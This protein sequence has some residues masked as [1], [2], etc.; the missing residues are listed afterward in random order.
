M[1]FFVVACSAVLSGRCE[2]LYSDMQIPVVRQVKKFLFWDIKMCCLVGTKIHFL[3][4][5]AV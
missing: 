3:E 4:C 2:M 1:K 5:E